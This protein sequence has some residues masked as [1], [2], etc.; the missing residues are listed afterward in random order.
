MWSARLQ[1]IVLTSAPPSRSSP[2]G[3][4]W[5]PPSFT[6]RL[7]FNLRCAE[8]QVLVRATRVN[9]EPSSPADAELSRRGSSCLPAVRPH[10]HF[11]LTC[12]CHIPEVEVAFF[13][14]F[15]ASRCLHPVRSA[16]E[17]RAVTTT[18]THTHGRG[19]VDEALRPEEALLRSRPS[20]ITLLMVEG[21]LKRGWPTKYDSFYV[22]RHNKY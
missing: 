20:E 21:Q 13:S 2:P 9:G 19:H 18:A 16:C 11:W 8:F 14:Q 6:G 7:G 5:S 10:A 17:R 1:P 15:C 4:P 22:T 12:A 3:S